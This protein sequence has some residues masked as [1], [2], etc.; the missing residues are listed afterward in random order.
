MIL[1]IIYAFSCSSNY[2]CPTM[3]NFRTG[4]GLRLSQRSLALALSFPSPARAICCLSRVPCLA[5]TVRCHA[6]SLTLS[7][8][9][10]SLMSLL[11]VFPNRLF[12]SIFWQQ[13]RDCLNM[14]SVFSIHVLCTCR[15]CCC[16][17]RCRS[18]CC[19]CILSICCA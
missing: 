19:C 5:R 17:C 9:D 6:L 18:C 8:R 12:L 11:Q 3:P 14:Y 10:I 13:Q 4:A 16:C 15:C 2:S 7:A 1:Y